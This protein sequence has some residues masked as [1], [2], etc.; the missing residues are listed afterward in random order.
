M[1]GGGNRGGGGVENAPVE[2]GEHEQ[3]GADSS[4]G[5]WADGGG[6]AARVCMR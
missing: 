4:S 2:G 6:F 5:A 1:R 3:M